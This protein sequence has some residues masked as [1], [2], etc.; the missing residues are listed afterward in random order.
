MAQLGASSVC[1]LKKQQSSH[2]KLVTAAAL[3]NQFSHTFRGSHWL[4][5]GR[6]NAAEQTGQ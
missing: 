1:A 5:R 3:A 4:S 2:S 6:V